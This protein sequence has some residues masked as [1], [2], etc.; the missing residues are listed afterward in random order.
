MI[1]GDGDA[2]FA[3]AAVD[4]KMNFFG[5]VASY[6]VERLTL[7]AMLANVCHGRIW[8]PGFACEMHYRVNRVLG[9]D[10]FT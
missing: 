10:F 8:Q 9:E 4:E 6:S 3:V 5:A 2:G 7:L 1:F